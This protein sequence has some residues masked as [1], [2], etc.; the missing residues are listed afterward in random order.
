[1]FLIARTGHISQDAIQGK[2]RGGIV[3]N[4]ILQ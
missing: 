3:A 2:G 4:G 1:M